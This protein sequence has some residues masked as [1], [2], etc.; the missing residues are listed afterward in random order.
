MAVWVVIQC[1]RLE[2]FESDSAC[3]EDARDGQ[4]VE[5]REA[6]GVQGYQFIKESYVP[7]TFDVQALEV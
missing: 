2:R 3:E 5:T 4:S 1:D 7:K 6:G